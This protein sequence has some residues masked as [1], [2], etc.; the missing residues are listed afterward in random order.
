LRAKLFIPR[1]STCKKATTWVLVIGLCSGS[2][3]RCLRAKLFI[4]RISTYK[5]ATTWVLSMNFHQR[6]ASPWLTGWPST[7]IRSCCVL[8]AFI[9]NKSINNGAQALGYTL[10]FS[11]FSLKFNIFPFSASI[12]T[13]STQNHLILKYF[14]KFWY[15][16]F[17]LL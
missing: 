3:L 12:L 13:F 16:P 11:L 5:N 7:R 17:F 2:K 4:P 8:S 10:W 14:Y 1:I 15:N 6:H 9:I